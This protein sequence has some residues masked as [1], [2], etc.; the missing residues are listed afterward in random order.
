MPAVFIEKVTKNNIYCITI[1][2]RKFL[3]LIVK[4]EGTQSIAVIYSTSV[5]YS[6]GE[7]MSAIGNKTNQAFIGTIIVRHN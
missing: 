3:T 6:Y 5:P 2:A 7:G 1:R 4:L